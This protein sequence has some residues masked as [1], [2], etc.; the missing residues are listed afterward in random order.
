MAVV[1]V[2]LLFDLF[3]WGGGGRGVGVSGLLGFMVFHLIIYGT[4][5]AII[6]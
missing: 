1:A 4:F 2:A 6:S 5:S 3:G